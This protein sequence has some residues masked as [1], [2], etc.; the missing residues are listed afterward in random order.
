[1]TIDARLNKLMPVLSARERAILVLESWKRG[2]QEDPKWRTTMPAEQS[3]QFN[4]LIELMNGSVLQMGQYITILEQQVDKLELRQC[5]LVTLVLWEEQLTAVRRAARLT[6]REPVT[7]SD[8]GAKQTALDEE[9]ESVGDL[10]ELLVDQHGDWREEDFETLEGWP[11]PVVSDAAWERV[12]AKE[13]KRLRRAVAAGELAG[14]GRGVSLC[15]QEGAFN[16]WAG[17][18][19]R[20]VPEDVLAFRVVPDSEA[21][22]A[23]QERAAIH[24]LQEALD[25]RPLRVKDDPAEKRVIEVIAGHLRTSLASAF[26]ELWQAMRAV[27]MVLAEVAAEFDGADPIRPLK[28]EVLDSARTRLLGLAEQLVLLDVEIELAEPDEELLGLVRR[29]VRFE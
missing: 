27:D 17:L 5:W 2:E 13:E 19:P 9:W 11:E 21:G 16:A 26:S 23:E 28:R 15:V 8:Y 6:L 1:M 24:R 14:R 3:R 25:W 18:A 20:P 4:R 22:D 10:A 7:G 12:R 29:M